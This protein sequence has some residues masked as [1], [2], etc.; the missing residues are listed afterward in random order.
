[1]TL[2]LPNCL[3][4]LNSCI[5]EFIAKGNS[6]RYSGESKIGVYK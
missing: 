1:M 3:I 4:A 6:V 5:P 2:T